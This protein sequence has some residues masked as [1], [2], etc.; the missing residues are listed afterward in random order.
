LKSAHAVDREYS[1]LSALNTKEVPVAKV[2][3]LCQDVT[4]IGSMFYVMEYLLGPVFWDSAL[5]EIE[6]KASRA[7]IHF[8]VVEILV[9]LHSVNPADVGLEDSGRHG[10][11]YQRQIDRWVTQYRSSKMGTIVAMEELIVWLG[12]NVPIDDGTLSIAH[13]D[14]RLDNLMFHPECEEVIAVLDWELPLSGTVLLI[15]PITVCNCVC[16]V[17]G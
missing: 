10:N 7:R 14:F 2:F 4:V 15:L 1:V 6:D 5:P 16:P 11:Y 3:H 9:K 13:A 12:D 8:Q 17:K